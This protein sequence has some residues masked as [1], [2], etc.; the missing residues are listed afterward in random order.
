M[1]VHLAPTI[2]DLSEIAEQVWSSYLDPEGEAPLFPVGPPDPDAVIRGD[3]CASVSIS[4]AWHGHLV[5]SCSSVAARYAAAALLMMDIADV[6][7]DDITD[8]LGELANV[9]GGNVKSTLPSVCTMSLPHVVVGPG[10]TNGW[11]MT[12]PVCELVSTWRGEMVLISVLRSKSDLAGIA[13]Q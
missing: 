8:A 6:T 2:E 10:V 3:V 13:D 7:P 11:P 4:G 9:V 5:V 12:V 1:S